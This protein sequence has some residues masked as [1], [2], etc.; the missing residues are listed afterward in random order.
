M[1]L[2]ASSHG[3]ARTLPR[4]LA[5][6]VEALELDQVSLVTIGL[7]EEIRLRA[8]LATPANVLASRLRARGWLLAT[9]QRGVYEF[10]PGSHAGPLSRGILTLPLQAALRAQPRPDVGLTFQSAAWALGLADRAPSRLEVAAPN[11]KTAS[12]LARV[13]GEGARVLV[14]T[15]HLP[16][17]TRHGVLVLSVESLL[18]HM[19]AHPRNVRSWTSALEWLPD[20]AADASPVRAVIE[21]TDRPASV[22]TRLSYLLSGL[23]PDI[24]D[25]VAP[26]P[27]G[28]VYFGPR[29]RLLR[30]DATRQ[31][32]DTL[33]PFDPRTLPAVTR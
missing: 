22:A 7:I 23:R 24:A 14:F 18:V 32:A 20:I 30:H 10:A 25:A 26:P 13:L 1:T 29:G 27:R 12:R 8:G 33:L 16:W 28:K 5:P 19:A 11:A 4:G 2:D 17:E 15:P 9:P 21:V 6:I 31:V 3:A